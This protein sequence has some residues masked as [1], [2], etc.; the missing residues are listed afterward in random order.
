MTL[1]KTIKPSFLEKQVLEFLKDVDGSLSIKRLLALFFSLI[2]GVVIVA[3]VFWGIA[4]SAIIV[5]FLEYIIIALVL[6]ITSEKFSKRGLTSIEANDEVMKEE[7][8]AEIKM[9]Q[10][11][12]K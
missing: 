10:L 8:Q 1:K 5:D 7:A 6:G 12:T 9:K 3:S 4:V 2:A 11:K